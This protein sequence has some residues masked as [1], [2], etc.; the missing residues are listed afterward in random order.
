[1]LVVV[2]AALLAILISGRDDTPRISGA[3]K[4]AVATV[5]QFETALSGRDWAGICDRLYTKRARAAAGGARCAT[6]LAQSAGGLRAPQVRIV[7]VTVRG[8]AASVTVAASVNGRAAVTD[9]IHLVREGGRF[10]I[11]SAGGD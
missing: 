6:T 3:P 9:T 2:G 7:A 5:T 1:V 10:R 4:D 11:E 8:Q